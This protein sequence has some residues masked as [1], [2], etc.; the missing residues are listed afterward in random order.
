[1]GMN[2]TSFF[3]RNFDDILND[4]QIESNVNR[5]YGLEVVKKSSEKFFIESSILLKFD[6]NGDII[7]YYEMFRDITNRK[8]A[9]IL[10]QQFKDKLEN[11]YFIINVPL[12]F[13][14]N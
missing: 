7:R 1:M 4:I 6:R 14:T 11:H 10:E 2:Y 12:S 8:K 9:Q 5:P 13:P 3:S